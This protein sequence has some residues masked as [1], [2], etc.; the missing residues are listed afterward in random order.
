MD[1]E[2]KY[3]TLM[4]SMLSMLTGFDFNGE[5]HESDE[6]KNL[7]M[8]VIIERCASLSHEAAIRIIKGDFLHVLFGDSNS[9]EGIYEFLRYD[10]LLVLQKDRV[11]IEEKKQKN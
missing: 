3:E 4:R 1:T 11:R 5:Y 9:H 2:R 8:E 7:V 10:V 6:F